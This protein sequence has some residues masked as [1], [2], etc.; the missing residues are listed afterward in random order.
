MCGRDLILHLVG[1]YT[2]ITVSQIRLFQMMTKSKATSRNTNNLHISLSAES[3]LAFSCSVYLFLVRE[4]VRAENTK[5]LDYLNQAFHA[6]FVRAVGY[7]P[8]GKHWQ[9]KTE[10]HVHKLLYTAT[11]R[12]LSLCWT[13]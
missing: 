10:N 3:R 7:C 2:K 9:Y 12:L 5:R 13:G 6:V 4:G 11:E 1:A 8:P